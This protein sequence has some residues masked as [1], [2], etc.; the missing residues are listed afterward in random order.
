[1]SRRE[2]HLNINILNSGFYASAWRAPASDPS[3]FVD[4]NHYVRNARIA[5]RGKFDAVFLA[6][7]P[8]FAE[9]PEYRPYQALEPTII[10]ATVAAH[11]RHI[12][13]IGTASTSFNDPYNIARRFATLD[14]AS[15]GRVG[16]NIVTTADS[17]AA[18]NFG[19]DGVVAHRERYERAAEFADVVVKLW[20]SWEDGALVGDKATG[21]F[22]DI[23]RVHP[24]DHEGA[25]FKVRGPLNVPRSRQG[26]PVLVQA[27]GSG[28]GRDL[29]AR[30][31]EAIFSVART[32]EEGIAFAADVRARARSL[33][34][35]GPIAFLP[36]LSTL[37]GATE[38][39]AR[40]REEEL[41]ELFPVEYGL[42][43]I[44]GLLQIDPARLSF[45]APLP[46][47]VAPPK[48]GGHTFS[49]ATIELARREKLTVRQLLHRLGTGTG[50]RLLVGTPETI[51]DDIEAWFLSGAADGFN[52]MPDV[53]PEG[54][55]VFVDHVVPLLQ[56]KG[57]FRTEY[58]GETLRDHLGLPRP[59]TGWETA[60]EAVEA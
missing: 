30:H 20:D 25:H 37:I 60:S 44:A 42:A 49:G 31:A 41:W 52:L 50:H 26:R 29:A 27:G 15:N 46:D 7:T 24:I 39:D 22:V 21:R 9:R 32:Q 3:A 17:A 11:T 38:E 55:E 35:T 53:L 8:V 2:L 4:V 19:L 51:A 23:G 33:G 1:M 40:R 58:R 43:R 16:W 18:R 12:G 10:L 54:L 34:R 56:R 47:D 28:D 6:D 36:G 48:D 59:A 5:E 45:D 13:L 14:L 57:I